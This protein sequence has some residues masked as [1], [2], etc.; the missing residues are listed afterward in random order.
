MRDTG[1][2]EWKPAL[3]V[4]LQLPDLVHFGLSLSTM[5]GA[6]VVDLLTADGVVVPE[7]ALYGLSDLP[8]SAIARIAA[9]PTLLSLDVSNCTTNGTTDRSAHLENQFVEDIAE[10]HPQLTF[11]IKFNPQPPLQWG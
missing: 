5:P 9:R 3:K 1:G 10:K 2:V 8:L 6:E 7:I 11:H 4:F